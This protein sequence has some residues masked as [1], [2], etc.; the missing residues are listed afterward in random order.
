MRVLAHIHTF[1]NADS[2]D[3]A[4]EALLR[5]NPRYEEAYLL[6]GRLELARGNSDAARIAWSHV[7]RG[8]AA[9]QAR[10]LL[11]GLD[12]DLRLGRAGWRAPGGHAAGG[13]P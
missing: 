12:S 10:A 7:R 5:Q 13:R 1:N 9:M 8:P 4:I 3:P 2:I 11:D 6:R